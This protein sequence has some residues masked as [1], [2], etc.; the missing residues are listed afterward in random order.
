M[1]LV[2]I[3]TLFACD[4]IRA[5]VPT[6]TNNGLKVVT[7]NEYQSSKKLADVQCTDSDND[8]TTISIESVVPPNG[9]CSNCFSV[10]PSSLHKT[11]TLEFS[12]QSNL[13]YKTTPKYEIMLD[14]TDSSGEK[15]APQFKVEVRVIPNTPPYLPTTPVGN[16]N[17]T[18][19]KKKGDAVFDVQC[20]DANSDPLTY[21][22]RA[23]S[24]AEY[25]SMDASGVVR[26]AQDLN[27]LCQKDFDFEV[28][29]KDPTN[30][31]V[32]P[33]NKHI[34]LNGANQQ[35]SISGLNV[36]KNV[37]E[38]KP[39]GYAVVNF[40]VADDDPP[41][42]Q[43]SVV[44]S[45]SLQYFELGADETSI[46][47]KHT[48]DYERSDTRTTTISVVCTDTFCTSLSATVTISISDTND[49]IELSPSRVYVTEEEGSIAIAPQWTV[50]D[51]DQGDSVTYSIVNDTS[52][53]YFVIDASTGRI[54]TTQVYDVDAPAYR[55]TTVIL[56]IQGR[57]RGGSSS[58]TTMTI[59]INDI[60]DNAP[61]FAGSQLTI[62]DVSACTAIGTTVGNITATDAD[63]AFQGNNALRYSGS[64]GQFTIVSDGNIIVTSAL[65]PNV[66]K[67]VATAT[68]AG[69]VPSSRS[70][71]PT[72]VSVI[73]V[74]CA[75]GVTA[76][77]AP[78]TTTPGTGPTVT[79][80]GPT[81]TGTGPTVAPG[82]TTGT[83]ASAPSVVPPGWVNLTDPNV[84]GETLE[85]NFNWIIAGAILGGVAVLATVAMVIKVCYPSRD[86]ARKMRGENPRPRNDRARHP[87][88]RHPDDYQRNEIS[89]SGIS[90]HNMG[91]PTQ[92]GKIQVYDPWKGRG[93][94]Y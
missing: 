68:D 41:N 53:G 31:A 38:D 66:Y 63:T 40:T 29:C 83:V 87:H 3:L 44:P 16:L 30:P 47:V 23:L 75:P 57:D 27:T 93:L 28:T 34:Q 25:F 78:A 55:N 88:N 32:G 94:P 77:P 74:A 89:P 18:K 81:V 21:T 73:V 22:F 33:F 76:P 43:I 37:P 17:D 24:H 12:L 60:N 26:A 48:L 35:P 15:A 8:D 91:R 58:T 61:T 59:N 11:Y 4:Q 10:I 56:E 36:M 45:V 49:P 62:K 69:Q 64:N 72:D 70:S 20:T 5:A 6:F 42:C 39:I 92:Q 2:V 86:N 54:T 65:T 9:P 50:T 71:S 52:V 85:H 80:T 46:I 13:D 1:L 67:I 84:A 90:Y 14:C 7:I 51:Q 19:N 82:S 79:G